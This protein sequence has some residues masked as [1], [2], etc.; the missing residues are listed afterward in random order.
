[1]SRSLAAGTGPIG[2]TAEGAGGE[3]GASIPA[4]AQAGSSYQLTDSRKNELLLQY[5]NRI[6]DIIFR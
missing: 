2:T 6:V 5:I 1:M 4:A 3:P